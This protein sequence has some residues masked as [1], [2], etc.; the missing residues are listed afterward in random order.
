VDKF[1]RP[2][3]LAIGEKMVTDTD[4]L[5]EK[6]GALTFILAGVLFFIANLIT[7]SLPNPPSAET[8]FIKW[9]SEN[10]IY[11]S[12]QNEILFFATISLIPSSFVL[13]KL[14]KK[15]TSR[16]SLLGLGLMLMAIPVL[17]MLDIVAGRLVYP[18]Y[19]IN[20]SFDILKLVLSIYH[21]GM[22]AVS[23]IFGMSIFLIS[24]ATRDT[25]FPK[26]HWYVGLITGVM[27]IIGSYPWL[28]GFFFNLIVIFFFSFWLVLNGIN[29]LFEVNKSDR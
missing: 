13:Y 11:L 27:Q 1:L 19:D 9:L 15:T 4:K 23:I 17:A 16:S 21:G 3:K 2:H 8:D 6:F 26:Y 7:I 20:L 5:I 12:I 25:I 22:H 29:I 24:F 10:R 14:L 28:T 18:V